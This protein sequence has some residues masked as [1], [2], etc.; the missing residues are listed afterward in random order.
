MYK[1]SPEVTAFIEKYP[2]DVKLILRQIQ[3]FNATL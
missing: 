2:K 1:K 3:V